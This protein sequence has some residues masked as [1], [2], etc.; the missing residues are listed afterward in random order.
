MFY[1]P[2]SIVGGG[3][4]WSR[5]FMQPIPRAGKI[6]ILNGKILFSALNKF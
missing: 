2:R 4:K 5:H 1:E 6:N 3:G